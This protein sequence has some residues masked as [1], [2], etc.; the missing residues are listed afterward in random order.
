MSRKLLIID[1]QNDFS[2]KLDGHRSDG[3]LAVKDAN[4][5][6]ENIAKLINSGIF[7]E[8]HV[9]LDTHTPYHIGH[10]GFYKNAN[11]TAKP[12]A[13]ENTDFNPAGDIL[14]KNIQGFSIDPT[15]PAGQTQLEQYLESYRNHHSGPVMLWPYHCLE[16][17]KGHEIVHELI[18][19]LKNQK[20]KVKYHIK[21]QN[22]MAEMYS[23]FSAAVPPSKVGVK[24]PYRYKGNV[25]SAPDYS[26]IPESREANDYKTKYLSKGVE[27]YE[28]AKRCVNLEVELNT[29]LLDN[30]LGNNSEVYIC[31]EAKSH[32]VKDS[33]MDMLKY[34]NHRYRKNIFLLNDC[35]SPVVVEGLDFLTNAFKDAADNLVKE[36]GENVTTSTELL[37]KYQTKGGKRR[38]STKKRSK[39]SSK[40]SKKR[41]SKKRSKKSTKKSKK[42]STKK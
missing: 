12:W 27:S 7:D 14:N 39:K 38:K 22:E 25:G 6:Y 42:R 26:G 23:I 21:G 36:F 5:D 18:E 1:P 32:C 41:S 31:G 35:T 2:P 24:I 30:L 3:A 16:G 17:K 13:Q 19:P 10:A 9:S 40:K 11:H 28:Q 4:K 37:T 29:G 15:N 34:K 20:G 33:A 8:I